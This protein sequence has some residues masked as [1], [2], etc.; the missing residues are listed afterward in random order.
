MDTITAYELDIESQTGM[1]ESYRPQR[2]LPAKKQKN[3]VFAGSGDSLAA[4]MLAERHSGGL[5]RAADPLE[6]YRNPSIAESKD[7]YFV[8]VSGNTI[9]NVRAA[10]R[11]N[12][13]AITSD[14]AS[15]LA[16]A[17]G[18]VITV[19][20]GCGTFTAGSVTFLECALACV[21]LVR[22]IRVPRS[23]AIFNAARLAAR[24]RT[25]GRVFILGSY[26]TYPLAMYGAAKFYEVLGHDAHYTRMEQFSH[27]ELFCADKGDTV[28][29]LEE[30]NPHNRELRHSLKKAG[31]KT[32]QPDVPS[33]KIP[34]L[35]YCTVFLQML[36]LYEAKRLKLSECHF[37]TSK[38][39]KTSNDMIY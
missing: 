11:T 39:R 13:T 29:I 32:I 21:S 30:K 19:G 8:S 31:I 36:V 28:I 38:M 4:A 25:S 16:R 2:P 14:P 33:A 34:Q 9:S 3:T 7:V 27:M 22:R 35:V 17:S 20:P 15:R 10:K 26:H 5:A 37:V 6:L 18:S 12:S 1:L 23:R 24:T